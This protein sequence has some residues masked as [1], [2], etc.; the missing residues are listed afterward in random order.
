MT[1]RPAGSLTAVLLI[2]TTVGT[3]A[4][5]RTI[6]RTLVEEHL[7]ACA[8]IERIESVYRW[9][10]QVCQEDEWRLW[11][12]TAPD[13]AAQLQTRLHALHPYALPALYTLQPASVW[14]AFAQWV[15]DETR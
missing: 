10:G 7:C 4:D 12:K 14:P 6:A 8:Q 1:R 9:E 13:R 2:L 5:A 11:F 15:H 3:E